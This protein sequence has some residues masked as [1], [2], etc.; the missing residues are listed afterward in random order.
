MTVIALLSPEYKSDDP[1]AV[2]EIALIDRDA[3]VVRGEGQ[4]APILLGMDIGIGKPGGRW[5]IASRAVEAIQVPRAP[6]SVGPTCKHDAFVCW[7]VD[8]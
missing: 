7:I 2:A 4:I 8:A 5:S 3:P 1:V 6:A